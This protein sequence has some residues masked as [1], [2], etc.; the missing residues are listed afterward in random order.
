MP[1]TCGVSSRKSCSIRGSEGSAVTVDFLCRISE[2]QIRMATQHLTHLD[3][4]TA[5]DTIEPW[6]CRGPRRDL[7]R[8]LRALHINDPVSCEK[9]FGLREDAVRNRHAV[10]ACANELGL[11][12]PAQAFGGNEYAVVLELL[13]E[14]AHKRDVCLHILLRPLGVFGKVGLRS[15]HY[16]NVFHVLLLL[17]IL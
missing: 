4:H 13:A 2:S 5:W 1:S 9:L 3:R 17:S 7:V 11:V 15:V 8:L 10:L 12:G 16:Q 14:R 6:R